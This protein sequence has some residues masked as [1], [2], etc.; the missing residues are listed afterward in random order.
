MTKIKDCLFEV[1]GKKTLE[2]SR[3][4][5]ASIR[6]GQES[7]KGKTSRW[8]N[9]GAGERKIKWSILTRMPDL[10]GFRKEKG[11]RDSLPN[12]DGK[13]YTPDVARDE[14]KKKDLGPGEPRGK[15]E[16]IEVGREGSVW[17]RIKG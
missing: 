9:G 16:K 2:R 11:N 1:R 15:E 17:T 12:G 5:R 6:C 4:R 13:R 7:R 10:K 8:G 14:K 3:D